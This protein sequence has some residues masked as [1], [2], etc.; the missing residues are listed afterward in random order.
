[1][2]SPK[3]AIGSWLEALVA[4]AVSAGSAV[5]LRFE[6][7][8][9]VNSATVLALVQFLQR[10]RAEGVSCRVV[11]DGQRRWQRMTFDALRP[12]DREDGLLTFVPLGVA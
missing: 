11:F 1:M 4:E 3:E 7:L 12:L 5:E 9:H 8:E 10:S 2:R 6:L